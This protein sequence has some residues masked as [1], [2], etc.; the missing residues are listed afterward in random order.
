MDS[1][2]KKNKKVSLF[3]PRPALDI[4]YKLTTMDLQDKLL[5]TGDEKGNIYRFFFILI[6][7]IFI[8]IYIL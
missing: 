3:N 1:K 5:F 8:Y 7:Y 2:G 6:S 4:N